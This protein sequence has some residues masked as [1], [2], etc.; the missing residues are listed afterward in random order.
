MAKIIR[1]DG[2]REV[3]K[4][5]YT[6]LRPEGTH[7]KYDYCS[8]KCRNEFHPKYM[9]EKGIDWQPPNNEED[10]IQKA[11]NERKKKKKKDLYA[12][13]IVFGV[14]ALTVLLIVFNS[15]GEKS[16]TPYVVDKYDIIVAAKN[17]VRQSLKS[18]KTAEFCNSAKYFDI[19][20]INDK[21]WTVKGCVDAQNSFGAMIRND[22][23][24]K[25]IISKDGKKASCS[26]L[27]LK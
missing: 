12:R 27:I 4:G 8:V 21:E 22:F 26:D 17:C 5:D 14:I 7:D 18:P 23:S 13:L 9:K 1:C 11:K 16:N 25:V 24:L 2:C 3:I 15:N 10:P 19:N 20:K 6:I